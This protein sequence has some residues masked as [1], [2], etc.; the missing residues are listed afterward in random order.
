[1]A[2]YANELRQRDAGPFHMLAVAVDTYLSAL[3]Y[4]SPGGTYEK[5]CLY[6]ILRFRPQRERKY[7][8]CK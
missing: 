1:M 3:P 8:P 4:K 6:V 7:S 2:V 5:C